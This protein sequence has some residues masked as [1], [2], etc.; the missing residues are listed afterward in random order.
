MMVGILRG[1][2]AASAFPIGSVLIAK[3]DIEWVGGALQ[4]VGVALLAF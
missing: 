1:A 4:G 2:L 3:S